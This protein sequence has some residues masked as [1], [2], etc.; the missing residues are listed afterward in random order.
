MEIL[1]SIAAIA[2]FRDRMTP[3]EKAQERYHLT[4]GN[5]D[6]NGALE[7]CLREK[8]QRS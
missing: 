6:G 2:Q 4:D 3:E 1:V 5:S 7:S 8:L